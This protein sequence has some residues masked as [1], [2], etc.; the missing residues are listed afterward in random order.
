[1]VKRRERRRRRTARVAI[2]VAATADKG[3]KKKE[4]KEEEDVDARMPAPAGHVEQPWFPM[5]LEGIPARGEAWRPAALEPFLK[6]AFHSPCFFSRLIFTCVIARGLSS[7]ALALS[8]V[9]LR[10]L[11]TPQAEDKEREVLIGVKLHIRKQTN[12]T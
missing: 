12:I 10:C 3:T 1:M 11:G 9:Y 4:I 8:S 5:P 6:F 7:S 2:E